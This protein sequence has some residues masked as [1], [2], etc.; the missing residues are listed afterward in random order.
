MH[1]SIQFVLHLLVI[2]S[3]LEVSIIRNDH[4]IG[5][6]FTNSHHPFIG[7]IPGNGSPDHDHDERD[8]KCQCGDLFLSKKI[9]SK[10]IPDKI[11]GQ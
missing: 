11:D 8:V 4:V 2:H 3:D 9:V 10:Y 7:Y 5:F 1:L 6:A